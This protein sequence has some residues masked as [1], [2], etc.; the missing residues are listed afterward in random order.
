M[1]RWGLNQLDGRRVEDIPA[2][3]LVTNP[4]RTNLDQLLRDDRQREKHLRLQ[5]QQMYPG[6]PDRPE[7][8]LA[9]KANRVAQ[10]E[11]CEARRQTPKKV[12]IELTELRGELKQHTREYKLLI[13][14]VR[15]IAQNAEGQLAASLA[16]HMDRPAE[17]KRLLQNVFS[18]PG[19]VRV[20][21]KA[22][23]VSLAPAANGP[24]QSALKG[25]F[26]E[27]NRR[28]L[29]HPG[30]PFARPIRFRPQIP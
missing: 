15:C 26:A 4:L 16:A 8:K 1:E 18:A 5:L 7:L 24:E 19:N 9:L 2:G 13:D 20:S 10:R 30:D 25:F 21:T 11:I 6:H 23:T 12:P 3:T 29:R 28:R 22:I 17:A 27:F 14:T